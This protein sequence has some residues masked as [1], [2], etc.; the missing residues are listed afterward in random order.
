[1]SSELVENA[2]GHTLPKAIDRTAVSPSDASP[3]KAP[4]STVVLY[5]TDQINKLDEV[6]QVLK[7]SLTATQRDLDESMVLVTGLKERLVQQ[8]DEI[9][10]LRG[11]NEAKESEILNVLNKYQS[12][13]ADVEMLD[14]A[15]VK[16]TEQ[17]DKSEEERRQSDDGKG[18]AGIFSRFF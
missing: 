9:E 1:M 4:D 17:L 15:I 11:L 8:Q 7:S 5:Y 16:L 13:F 6:V 2:I 18:G 12:T 14:H 10:S 3:T